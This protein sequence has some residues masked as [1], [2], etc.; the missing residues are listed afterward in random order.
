MDDAGQGAGVPMTD[1]L[2]GA[3]HCLSLSPLRVN[4]ADER[5]VAPP[6]RRASVAT[7]YHLAPEPWY[8]AQPSDVAYLPEAFAAD[9]FVHLT[10]GLDEVLAAGDRYYLADARPYLL[11]TVEL[12]RLAADTRVRYDDP[13]RRFPHVYG[14]LDRAAIVRVERVTRDADGRFT[15]VGPTVGDTD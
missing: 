6:R 7:A 15:G 8:R 2:V 14:P 12:D 13:E 11:L 9:G 3:A 1:W 10:H 5:G 4:G